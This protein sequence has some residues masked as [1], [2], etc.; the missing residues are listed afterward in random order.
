MTRRRF[1]H[2]GARASARA[3]SRALIV[4]MLLGLGACDRRD[5]PTAPS[6]PPAI[7]PDR[8]S[9]PLQWSSERYYLEITG[10]DMTG[11][12]SLPPCSPPSV[13]PG[14]KSVNTFVWFDWEGADLVGRSRPPYGATIEIRMRRVS[15]SP[16][17]VAITGTVTGAVV[18]EYDRILGQR[19]SVF[20]AY[21]P[22]I[23]EGTVPPRAATDTR[24]PVLGGLLRGQ[25]GFN[26]SQ[27]RSSFCSNVRYYLEPAPPG[28]V[29][30]DPNVPPWVPG[31]HATARA[32]RP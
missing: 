21:A 18:D 11:D 32:G 17:G 22:L 12:P 8:T 19:N 4:A 9:T 24:G 14:G 23:M 31:L 6:P 3:A 29:H 2:A 15:S 26:D 27:G 30:D 20:N 7:E 10:G 13:P 28:G 1:S 5:E 25:S 16:L